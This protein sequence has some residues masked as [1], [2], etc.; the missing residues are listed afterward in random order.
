VGRRC[1]GCTNPGE[2]GLI[3]NREAKAESRGLRACADNF[4]R[5]RKYS[6]RDQECRFRR[7]S[8]RHPDSY[9]KERPD[10]EYECLSAAGNIRGQWQAA[11][12]RRQS[13]AWS[14]T[15]AT[16][17][18][19]AHPSAGISQTAAQNSEARRLWSEGVDLQHDGNLVEAEKKFR[20]ALRRYP[21]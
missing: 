1:S 7:R 10:R 19:V 9:P 14:L 5:I 17:L 15:F 18:A 20:D 3:G 4:G 16:A 11:P 13:L 2:T 8:R 21:R 6:P 12:M